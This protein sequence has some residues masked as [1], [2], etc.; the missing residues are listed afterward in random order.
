MQAFKP[1]EIKKEFVFD[2]WYLERPMLLSSLV[3]EQVR[4]SCFRHELETLPEMNKGFTLL[5]LMSGE[6]KYVL[7]ERQI[8]ASERTYLITAPKD[9]WRVQCTSS[10]PIR[11]ISL[12]F[13]AA[14]TRAPFDEVFQ[15]GQGG[16]ISSGQDDGAIEELLLGLLKELTSGDRFAKSMVDSYLQQIAV[17][18]CRKKEQERPLQEASTNML[19]KKELV[20]ETVRY[21]DDRLLEI[22]ELGHVAE[23]M[24]YSYSH[25]S[26]VFRL[27]MGEALQAYW[28]RKR[29]L[30]AMKYLQA[31]EMSVTRIAEALHY[32][33]I[34]SFSK[35][36]KKV[37]GLTPSEY[38]ELYGQ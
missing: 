7:G 12:R 30:K 34:H 10:A 16:Q 6:G 28:G 33:S 3:L 14:S 15:F 35:A 36:F 24:G 32:Q 17:R 21:M 11:L 25:L 23:A 13:H 29:A 5:Y 1:S 9:H 4:D 18:L 8:D 38:Q 31:K 20:Y 22:K 2:R 27:E 37:V 19:G 26:H